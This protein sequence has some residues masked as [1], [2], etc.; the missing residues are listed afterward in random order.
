[1]TVPPIRGRVTTGASGQGFGIVRASAGT[2]LELPEVGNM[3]SSLGFGSI[4]F[5]AALVAALSP[6]CSCSDATRGI[7][8]TGEMPNE[9]PVPTTCD[10][11]KGFCVDAR[12]DAGMVYTCKPPLPGC[13]CDSNDGPIACLPQGTDPNVISSCKE[14]KS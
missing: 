7:P 1:M 12:N 13:S 8:C 11:M 2:G 5:A 10:V 6:G 3:R 9:C 14:G 4:V